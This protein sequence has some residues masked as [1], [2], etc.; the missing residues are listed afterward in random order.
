MYNFLAVRAFDIEK[1]SKETTDAVNE[2]YRRYTDAGL[3]EDSRRIIEEFGHIFGDGARNN[4]SR[5]F[6][7]M[8]D[9]GI[10]AVGLRQ[11]SE[12]GADNALDS[13]AHIDS[14]EAKHAK[15]TNPQIRDVSGNVSTCFQPK[16]SENLIIQKSD[17]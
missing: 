11:Q 15:T 13:G 6:R 17:L 7:Q 10:H 3:P 1:Q 12:R 5:K 4:I 8:A 16:K 14:P 9:R 2:I